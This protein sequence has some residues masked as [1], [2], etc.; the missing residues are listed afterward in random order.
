M[1]LL[2]RKRLS[3]CRLAVEDLPLPKTVR[4]EFLGVASLFFLDGIEGGCHDRGVR[5]SGS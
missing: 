1:V 5:Q 4:G 2:L 3:L